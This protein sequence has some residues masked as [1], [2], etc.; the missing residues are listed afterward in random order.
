MMFGVTKVASLPDRRRAPLN[1]LK[2]ETLSVGTEMPIGMR[3]SHGE[4]S[5]HVL[6]PGVREIAVKRSLWSPLGVVR[7]V[8][9][10]CGVPFVMPSPLFLVDALPV[11][12]QLGF[13]T[14]PLLLNSSCENTSCGSRPLCL[15]KLVSTV[16]PGFLCLPNMS[17]LQLFSR[18]TRA[19]YDLELRFVSVRRTA[20]SLPRSHCRLPC[21]TSSSS[22]PSKC[23]LKCTKISSSRAPS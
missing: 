11:L 21:G 19:E 7:W 18:V 1:E 3:R 15:V 5:C 20:F 22:A 10:G 8:C 6:L 23:P 14:E 9:S 16:M 2:S 12:N 13:L 4:I 17:R